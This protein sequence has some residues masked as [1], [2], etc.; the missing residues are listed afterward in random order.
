MHAAM[1]IGVIV[2][3]IA[4]H[5]IDDGARFLRGGGIIEIHQRATV[6]LLIE[7]WEIAAQR[8]DIECIESGRYGT[9]GRASTVGIATNN[10]CSRNSLSEALW[11]SSRPAFKKPS[12]S[13]AMARA[14]SM[15]RVCKYNNC[16]S[17]SWP[18]VAPCAQ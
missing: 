11:Q 1:H 5:R 3:V 10:C 13:S 12:V 8:F 2:R 16:S 15:P 14:R 4:I 18:M 9:H 17:S 6:Y 7:Q